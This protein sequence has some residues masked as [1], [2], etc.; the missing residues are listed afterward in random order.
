VHGAA[1][2]VR[3]R[4][5]ESPAPD[6]SREADIIVSDDREFALAVQTADCV[7]LLMADRRTGAVAAAHAGWRGLAANVPGVAVAALA[8]E[9]GSLPGDLVVAIG[10]SIGACCYEVGTDVRE[11]FTS[12]GFESELRRWFA[13]GPQPTS[14]NPSMPAL[15]AGRRPGHWFFDGWS[16]ARDQLVRAGVPL[17]QIHSAVLCTASHQ[18]LCSY[19]R[20]AGAAGRIAAVIRPR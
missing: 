5:S 9:F 17:A 3:H 20:D 13:D 10:P 15:P 18:S 16:A 19:R 2:V 4:G 14:R 11:A 8:R 6:W 12:G 7:P 1:I